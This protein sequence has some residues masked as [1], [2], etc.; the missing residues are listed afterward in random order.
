MQLFFFLVL[1]LLKF[2]RIFLSFF[3]QC[4]ISFCHEERVLVSQLYPTL[5]DPMDCSP[6]GSSVRG[7]LQAKILE[8]VAMPFSKVSSRPARFLPFDS[9]NQS[10]LYMHLLPPSFSSPHPIHLSH[11]SA[12]DWAPCAMKQLLTSHPSHTR[13][14]VYVDAVS[15]FV[16]HSPSPTVSA[17]P[18]AT[19]ESP[20]LP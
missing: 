13:Q 17:R 2:K 9:A 1:F 18:C 5:C 19:A 6:P 7:I 16:P 20:F 12:S 8:W 15:S 14:C 3:L 10:Q 11:H 4:C